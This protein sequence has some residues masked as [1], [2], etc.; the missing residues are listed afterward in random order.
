MFCFYLNQYL[1][2]VKLYI[3]ARHY[4]N[5][6]EKAKDLVIFKVGTHFYPKTNKIKS[7]PAI[8]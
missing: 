4:N 3:D 6:Y 5:K 7:G 8:V 1:F 2:L